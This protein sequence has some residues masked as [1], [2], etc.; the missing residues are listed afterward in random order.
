VKLDRKEFLH[1]LMAG[2]HASMDNLL[3]ERMAINEPLIIERDG[4]I[5]KVTPFMLAEES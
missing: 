2:V 4:R 3:L 5:K 1:E